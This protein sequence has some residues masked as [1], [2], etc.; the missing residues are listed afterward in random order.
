MQKSTT[1]KI[2]LLHYP[3]KQYRKIPVIKGMT[4]S[5]NN[6]SDHALITEVKEVKTSGRHQ[7]IV[8]LKPKP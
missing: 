6:D 1:A 4:V 7:L 3:L 5:L 2:Y 8:N